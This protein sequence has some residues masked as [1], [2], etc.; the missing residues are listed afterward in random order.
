MAPAGRAR[1]LVRVLVR[2]PLLGAAYVALEAWGMAR[3]PQLYDSAWYARGG[4]RR[5]VQVLAT[6]VLGPNGIVLAA[7]LAFAALLAYPPSRCRKLLAH[8]PSRC[9]KLLA[10]PPSRCRKLLA[11][12]PSR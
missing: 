5:T 1:A 12:P 9:R 8:P 6:D 7:L 4:W 11:Y 3:A 10:H 2:A